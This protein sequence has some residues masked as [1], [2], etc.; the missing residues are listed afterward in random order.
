LPAA[1]AS[2]WLSSSPSPSFLQT[3]ATCSA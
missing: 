2:S 1:F 3:V